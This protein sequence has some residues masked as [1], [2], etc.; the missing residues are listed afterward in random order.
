MSYVI[1]LTHNYGVEMPTPKYF[2]GKMI[3]RWPEYLSSSAR[4]RPFIDHESAAE[5]MSMFRAVGFD[6]QITTLSEVLQ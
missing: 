4:A 1:Q 5:Y 2:T 6:G 3:E